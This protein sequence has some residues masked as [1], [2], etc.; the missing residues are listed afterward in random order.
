MILRS[1]TCVDA[2]G[3]PELDT[4]FIPDT[5]PCSAVMKLSR[6]DSAISSAVTFCTDEPIPRCTR[7]NPNSVTTTSFSI[8]ASSSICT[9]ICALVTLTDCGLQPIYENLSIAPC[10]AAIV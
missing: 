3:A 10:L 9:L 5:R 6:P 4:T 7:F 2:P 1:V 8:L